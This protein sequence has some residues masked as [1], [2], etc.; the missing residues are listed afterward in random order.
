MPNNAL[1]VHGTVVDDDVR[2]DGR[3]VQDLEERLAKALMQVDR[4]KTEIEQHRRERLAVLAVQ[5]QLEP[6]YRALAGIFGDFEHVSDDGA[7]GVDDR[8]KKIWDTW[9][10]KL[11]GYPAKIIDALLIQSD[12]NTTQLAIACGCKTQRISEG[13]MKLNRA[14]LITKNGG[15]FSLKAL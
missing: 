4:L 14:G 9:K 5:R 7:S 8:V 3:R 2:A 1:V 10:Q 13:I 15:R 11:P 6:F 12:M